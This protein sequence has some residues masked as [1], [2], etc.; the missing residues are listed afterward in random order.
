[1]ISFNDRTLLTCAIIGLTAIICVATVEAE[2]E[3]VSVLFRHGDRTPDDSNNEKYPNDPY[4]D[5]D[6]YPMGRGQLTNQGKRRE[7]TLGRFLRMKYG[8]FLKDLYT[9]ETVIG[10]SSEYDRTKMSLQ[11]VLAGLF[12][13]NRE[14]KWNLM[15]NWQPIPTNYIRRYEDNLFLPEDCPL[16]ETEYDKMLES[17]EGRKALSKYS[18]L[19]KNL[20]EWSGKNISTP[21]DMYYLYHTLM[22]E[23]SMDLTL[24]DW[25]YTV[26]PNG[27]LWNGTV[28]AY[29]AASFT[30]LLRRI[31]GGAY[32]REVT[33]TMLNF[34]TGRVEN[35]RKMYL[36]SGHESN[37]A[38]VMQSLQVY[39]PHVPEYSSA[40]ILE[41]HK[42][43]NEYYVKILN[44]LGIPSKIIELQIPG[45]EKLCPFDKFLELMEDVLPSDD[46]IICN[47]GVS[48]D[49]ADYKSNEELD[50][51]KYNLIRTAKAF[52]LD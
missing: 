11:L 16:Y 51:T 42:I 29:D 45:C 49:Y 40:V 27:D 5:Y 35:E 12:P 19:M 41:L 6:F 9:Q 26:F 37:V 44:Y 1:M 31:N 28:F 20:T 50:L 7:Y 33:K 23:Y 52:K 43:D 4:L 15:L 8:R 30:P 36:Y 10:V 47:K 14:Q 24:P 13:P 46:E 32:L 2:L 3:V 39:Y 17:P 21:W 48:K 25:A 18:D 38:A 22:A 34:I